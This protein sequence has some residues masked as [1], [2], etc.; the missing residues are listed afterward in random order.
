MAS[1]QEVRNLIAAA[2]ASENGIRVWTNNPTSA[3]S[4]ISVV[5]KKMQRDGIFPGDF[6]IAIMNDNEIWIVKPEKYNEFG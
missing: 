2:D 6:R 1:D 4:R 3:R 5:K